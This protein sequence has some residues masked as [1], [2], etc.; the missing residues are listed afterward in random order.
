MA[1]NLSIGNLAVGGSS[2][3]PSNS[4]GAPE[5]I[6]EGTTPLI[7]FRNETGGT[8]DYVV[9]NETGAFKIKNDTDNSTPL[10]ISSGGIASFSNGVNLGNT[11]SATATTLDGYEEGTFTVTANSDAT[12]V[13]SSE[14]G[15]YT[16]IG[17]CVYIRIAIAVS[18]TFTTNILGGLPFGVVH[19]DDASSWGTIGPVLKHS[20]SDL[21]LAAVQNGGQVV[22]LWAG[23]DVTSAYL[24]NSTDLYYRFSG[25]YYTDDA[26]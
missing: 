16:R 22:K 23:G 14:S 19:S 9:I 24:P 11:A 8:D 26:F 12:G 6:L 18:T 25:F 1:S 5:V 4:T 3:S 7:A 15:E 10:T 2:T 13:L 17:N 21:V 20:T